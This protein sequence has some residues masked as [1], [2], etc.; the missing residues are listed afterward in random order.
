MTIK[1]ALK[2]TALKMSLFS[3]MLI[4]YHLFS[5]YIANMMLQLASDTTPAK[6]DA[7]GA[8]GGSFVSSYSPF[9]IFSIFWFIGFL[10]IFYIVAVLIELGYKKIKSK[11]E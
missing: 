11:D 6:V 4:G 10:V 5:L 7:L 8:A 2:P 1:E 3:L 9:N